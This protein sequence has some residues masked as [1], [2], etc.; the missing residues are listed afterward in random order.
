[1]LK[2]FAD[3]LSDALAHTNAFPQNENLTDADIEFGLQKWEWYLGRIVSGLA[4]N[5][6][7]KE[8]SPA[9]IVGLALEFIREIEAQAYQL[10]NVSPEPE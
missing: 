1:M 5:P 3:E 10:D 2:S 4:A 9:F 7:L 8:H 6:G